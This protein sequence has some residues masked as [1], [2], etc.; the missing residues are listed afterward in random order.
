[1]TK[2]SKRPAATRD[3]AQEA[4]FEQFAK[5][6]VTIIERARKAAAK[7]GHLDLFDEL[8]AASDDELTE[9]ESKP[10]AAKKR[11]PAEK[12]RTATTKNRLKKGRR[13]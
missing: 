2:K 6:I 10:A 7:A 9:R 1:M 5:G 3:P 8:V 13:K 4:E 11:K 12:P